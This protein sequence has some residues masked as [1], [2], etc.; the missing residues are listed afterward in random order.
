[1]GGVNYYISISYRIT[2]CKWFLFLTLFEYLIWYLYPQNSYNF[3]KKAIFKNKKKKNI[4][5]FSRI[6]VFSYSTVDNEHSMVDSRQSMVILLAFMEGRK[7]TEF[8]LRH[9]FAHRLHG[10]KRLFLFWFA[11][12]RLRL[13]HSSTDWH[14]FLP[15]GIYI[16][17]IFF[18][19]NCTNFT[20]ILILFFVIIC[21]FCGQNYNLFP[22]IIFLSPT[23]YTDLKIFF[24]FWFA[25]FRLCLKHSSTDWHRFLPNGI[26]ISLI[27]FPT[28]C[29]N[30]TNI[31]ILFFVI[32]CGFCG[33]NYNLFPTIIFLSPTDYTDLKDCFFFDSLVL[34]VA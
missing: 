24:L 25:R 18:P 7:L 5:I 2:I 22:T 27:F 34:G 20:N 10:F 9:F 17:L 16:S 33:Q 3:Q 21:G 31:L 13:K 11:R 28:N 29:T 30:F 15:N 14:R 23:D 4:V 12:F 19:T 26:Y 6:S 32:I 8:C 1:M